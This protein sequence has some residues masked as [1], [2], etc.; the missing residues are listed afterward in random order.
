MRKLTMLAT[1]AIAALALLAVAAAPASADRPFQIN[2]PYG[3][4]CDPYCEDTGYQGAF[5]IGNVPCTASFDMRVESDGSFEAYNTQADCDSYSLPNVAW[6]CGGDWPGQIRLPDTG[7]A[8]VDLDAC[9]TYYPH[10][11]NWNHQITFDVISNNPRRWQ[12][13]GNSITS[14]PMPI[15]SAFFTDYYQDDNVTAVLL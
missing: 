6:E 1:A 11:S 8:Q 12:Q 3:N 9:L 14:A 7:P 4:P 5:D 10:S 13:V 2:D 15:D